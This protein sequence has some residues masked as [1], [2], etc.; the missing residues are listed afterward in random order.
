[1]S[2]SAMAA[3]AP[4]KHLA[5][6]RRAA[7]PPYNWSGLYLGANVGG[8]WS[9]RTLTI[10]DTVW[11]DPFSSAFIGGLQLGYNLQAGYFLVGVE[12]D[13]DW[14]TFGRPGF[15]VA[16]PLGPV[17]FFDRQ[18]W[19]STAAARFG[20]ALDRWLTYAKVGGGWA[21]DNARFIS[22]SG[23]PIWTDTNTRGGWLLGG[24]IE[25]GFKPN[26]TIKL[27]YDYLKLSDWTAPTIPAEW[28][29]DVQIIK[30]G[31]NYKF[32]SG[33]SD[34]ATRT[35]DDSTGS[36][37]AKG[38]AAGT[39]DL[40]KAS[41]NPI[42]SL[43]SVPFQNNTNPHVGPFNRTQNILNIEPVV[44][45]SLNAQWNVISR[46]IIPVMSQPN[47]LI[48]SST[49]GV[50]DI[51]ESLFFSPVNSG[52]KDFTWGFGPIVTAPSASDLILGTGRTLIGPTMVLV[53]TPGH[54]VIGVLANNQWSVGGAP[55][56]PSVN[57]FT[58]QYF[59]NYNIP[60]GHGW[61]LTSA[62]II[63]AD[64]TAAPGQQWTVPVG[65]GFGRVFKLGDQPID[66][67]IQG[68]YNVVRPDNGPTWSLRVQMSLLFPDK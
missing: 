7:P 68:F 59:I 37:R 64:W 8:A 39:E 44:P 55:G 57:F 22:P 25:Y 6:A 24:G 42:A 2:A 13:F 60:G 47:P 10:A 38:P 30:M 9:N 45:M 29:R 16:S 26:W 46:T 62:P 15:T 53:V 56:R 18:K 52:I 12:G 58:T 21:Q 23:A 5:Y 49:N 27:E 43:V 48:D 28:R 33:N 11:D 14:G 34:D 36:A 41:Q 35:P 4:V 67:S 20:I 31:M 3:E 40:A 19:I 1:M 54:W 50:G 61:F 65:G 66:A 17:Q 51:N 63:T 32:E